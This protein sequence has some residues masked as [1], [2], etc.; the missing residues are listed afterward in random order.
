MYLEY[1]P[2]HAVGPHGPGELREYSLVQINE[3][4]LVQTKNGCRCKRGKNVAIHL[5]DI[6]T[7]EK[8]VVLKR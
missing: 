2:P 7:K 1:V 6:S 8:W 4:V 3:F 5:T